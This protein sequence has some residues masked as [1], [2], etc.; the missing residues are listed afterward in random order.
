MWMWTVLDF[1]PMMISWVHSKRGSVYGGFDIG[2]KTY[3]FEEEECEEGNGK[4]DSRRDETR[5]EIRI[6]LPELMNEEFWETISW[7]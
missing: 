4:Y 1:L 3:F 2:V 5:E 7:A 6:L